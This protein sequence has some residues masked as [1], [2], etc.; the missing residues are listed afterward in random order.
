ML[1]FLLMKKT[2]AILFLCLL[3]SKHTNAEVVD[4]LNKLNN[5]FKTGVITQEEF[6]KGKSIIL[7]IKKTDVKKIK[8]L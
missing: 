8:Q 2:L 6:T 1:E 5:L 4:Q 7:G 3:L